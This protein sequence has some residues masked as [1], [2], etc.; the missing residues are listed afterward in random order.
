[1]GFWFENKLKELPEEQQKIF[2]F[3]Y[4]PKASKSERNKGISEEGTGSNTYNRKCLICGKWERKQGFSDDYT[5]HC[6]NPKWEKP[7]GNI[8][9]TVK[10]IKLMSYLITLT[11]REN[12]IVLDPFTGSGTTA[13]SS[14]LLKRRFIGFEREEEYYKIATERI[15]YY[16]NKETQA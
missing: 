10:P 12:D 6:Q 15:K 4:V 2:P 7:K 13:I 16:Q 8:H 11:T 9:A 3:L 1:M 5:C 14:I